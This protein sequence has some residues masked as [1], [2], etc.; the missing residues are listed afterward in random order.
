M[1]NTA[2]LNATFNLGP[3]ICKRSPESTL[4]DIL[5]RPSFIQLALFIFAAKFPSSTGLDK[6]TP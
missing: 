3:D 5:N 2:G 4:S 6:H 1:Y